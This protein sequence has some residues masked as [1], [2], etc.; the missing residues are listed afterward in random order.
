MSSR[1]IAMTDSL[2]AYLREHSLREPDVL[3]ALREET[4][5]NPRAVMQISPEQG[6]FMAL[7]AKL[8]G[9]K[10]CIEVGVFTGYSSLSVALALPSDGR[11]VACDVSEEWTAV[12]RRYWKLA[13]VDGKI[14]L[15]LASAVET[16]DALLATGGAGR[17][18]F[19]FI[20][21]DKTN[22]LAYYE[23]ILKLLRQGGLMAIDNTLWSGKVAELAVGDADTV[24]LRALN[25]F[26]HHDARVEMSLLPVGDGLTLVRKS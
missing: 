25:D 9:A 5:K 18:D 22:Y 15:K 1:T 19:A 26:V 14:E 11:I 2:Y 17:Y 16:L 13:G 21:A 6:Q 23:R 20:D 10:R 12:A 3:R 7:L 8:I 4:A 24:A